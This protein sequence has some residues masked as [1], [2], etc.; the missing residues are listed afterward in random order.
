MTILILENSL[1]IT[2]ECTRILT[3]IVRMLDSTP[4][5][6]SAV[7]DTSVVVLGKKEL[8]YELL[9]ELTKIYLGKIEI[10]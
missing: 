4:L 8:L 7:S 1:N 2:V 6:W 3:R 10:I 5:Q 9:L